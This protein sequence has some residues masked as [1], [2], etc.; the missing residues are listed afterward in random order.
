MPGK[1]TKPKTESIHVPGGDYYTKAQVAEL[2]GVIHQTVQQWIQKGW[3]PAIYIGG[4][5]LVNVKDLEG[6]EPPKP[7]RKP[8][9]AI[10]PQD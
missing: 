2:R 7:G 10:Q 8:G 4:A 9:H 3:L 1:P 6:F 5:Y